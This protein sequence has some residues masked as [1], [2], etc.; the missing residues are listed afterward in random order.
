MAYTKSVQEIVNTL[1]GECIGN[2]QNMAHLCRGVSIDTRELRES[3][4]YV[5]RVGLRADGHEFLVQAIEK[6]AVASIVERSALEKKDRAEKVKELSSN[7]QN[8][9]FIL[10]DDSTAALAILAKNYRREFIFPVICITG[11]NGKTTTKELVRQLLITLVG[12]GT[13]SERSFNNHVGLPR[14][15]LQAN[16]EDSWLLLEAG[17]NHQGELD[18]LG[19]VAE[20][21]LGAVLNVGPVH[22]EHFPSLAAIADAKCELL[23]R[24]KAEG[25]WIYRADDA[26]LLAAVKRLQ[27]RNLKESKKT[28]LM[29]TFALLAA[30]DFQASNVEL[31]QERGISFTVS[32]KN[33]KE[34]FTL[35]LFGTHN[36]YNALAAI[37]LVCRAFPKITLADA[38]SVLREA[39]GAS[40]RL[41]V[42]QVGDLRIINDAYNANPVSMQAGFDALQQIAETGRCGVVLG[43][44]LELGKHSEKFH[45]E[46]GYLVAKVGPARLISIGNF[47]HLVVASAKE[48]GLQNAVVAKNAE[49]AA[50]AVVRWREEGISTVFLKASRGMA[51]EKIIEFVSKELHALPSVSAK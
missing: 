21:D 50:Q 19:S 16:R 27:E 5:A 47:S 3:E 49:E 37:A 20:P 8:H 4:L 44:M 39:K 25:H 13:A 9:S 43:D 1:Q 45:R 2:A 12:S 30:A 42:V 32:R 17:M 6:G 38:S 23:S 46:L 41:E 40:M 26:E 34:R 10:V 51:L 31:N 11:S 33:E 48:K 24:V 7:Y 29:T 14:S 35:P 15:I 18:F 28:P 36:V 22:L